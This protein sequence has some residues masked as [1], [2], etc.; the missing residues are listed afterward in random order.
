MG[1]LRGSC[2]AGPRPPCAG[3]SLSVLGRGLQA[4]RVAVDV[5]AAP[6]RT[7]SGLAVGIGGERRSASVGQPRAQTHG[8]DTLD[9]GGRGE[10]AV[11]RTAPVVAR[12]SRRTPLRGKAPWRT[13]IRCSSSSATAPA[14]F[15]GPACFVIGRT[16]RTSVA[17]P[18][19]ELGRRRQPVVR[20]SSPT[21]LTGSSERSAPVEASTLVVGLLALRPAG[22]GIGSRPAARGSARGRRRLGRETRRGPRVVAAL[23]VGHTI[24]AQGAQQ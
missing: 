23:Q 4:G 17:T 8:E 21:T 16:A 3:G 5:V 10:H 14:T 9:V 22:D 1:R 13:P 6:G 20:H 2:R 19:H 24:E 15:G 7:L 18:H 12:R 11:A